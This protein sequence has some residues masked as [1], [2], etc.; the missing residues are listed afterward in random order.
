MYVSIVIPLYNK[1]L[2]IKRALDSVLIQTLND[3]EIIVVDDGSTDDGPDMDC[4]RVIS[5]QR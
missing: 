4:F 3:Y 5:V 1:A 2:F